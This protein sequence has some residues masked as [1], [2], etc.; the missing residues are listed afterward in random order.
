MELKFRYYNENTQNFRYSTDWTILDI[1]ESIEYFFQK[2]MEQ[3]YNKQVDMFI[4][5]ID[6]NNN[7]IYT[8]DIIQSES[9]R[10]GVIQFAKSKFGINWDYYQNNNSEWTEGTMYGSWGS[11][12]NLRSLDDDMPTK[13]KVIGNTYQN[14][15]LLEK[16]EKGE[17]INV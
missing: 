10:L 5:V 13:I 17:I 4:G 12:T 11:L 3:A 14:L 7:D 1:L 8:D 6:K 9:G 2:A 15:D 16:Y